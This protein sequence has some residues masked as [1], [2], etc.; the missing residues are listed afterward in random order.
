MT[1]PMRQQDL[2]AFEDAVRRAGAALDEHCRQIVTLIQPCLVAAGQVL[3]D[4]ENALDTQWP[5]W[6]EF[7]AD[8]PDYVPEP[9]YQG[10]HCLCA[11]AHGVGACVG[12][13]EPGLFVVG[14]L[15]GH[16][17]DIPV[18]RE[19]FEARSLVAS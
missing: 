13:A 16:R 12:E 8:V 4:F 5:G 15:D 10:C 17:L 2:E 19:C 1:E 18:C 6:R 11:V 14:W 3:R 9:A 7:A